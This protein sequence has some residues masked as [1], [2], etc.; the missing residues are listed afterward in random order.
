M[1]KFNKLSIVAI[2]SI[3]TACGGGGGGSN[4]IPGPAAFTSFPLTA[5]KSVVLSGD[6]A[7]GTYT[8]DLVGNVLTGITI[9]PQ[10]SG[11]T[12]TV[13]STSGAFSSYKLTTTSGTN[14][15]WTSPTD[16]FG[17]LN[18]NSNVEAAVSANGQNYVLAGR[19]ST[20][21]WSYQDFGIWVTGAGTGSGTYGAASFGAATPSGSIPT[22]G[23][24][25]YSGV[26]GGRF[27]TVGGPAYFTSSNLSS[28]VDFAA[29]TLSFTTSSTQ[30]ST[31]L[32]S[33][34]FSA[35]TALDLTGSLSY[36]AGSNQFTGNVNNTGSTLTGTAT[37]RFY[38][39]AAQEI[40]GT[41]GLTGSAGYYGGGF[42]AKK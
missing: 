40:G 23:T 26:T 28:N 9:N 11:A 5:G 17:I 7:Q 37:G 42:G 19:T 33:G 38:G 2:S 21:G 30:Q 34:S 15:T 14:V 13:T 1:S 24:A 27:G 39:P 36:N 31:T 3:L 29:R 35:N 32:L 16:T 6:S 10:Q 4:V 22:T 25:T 12:F 20:L 8:Y 18:S 41:F